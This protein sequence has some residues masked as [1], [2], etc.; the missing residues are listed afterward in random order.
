MQPA[1]H[2]AIGYLVWS[3]YARSR[4]HRPPTDRGAWIALFGALFPDLVDKPLAWSL[5][6]LPAGRSLAH[7]LLTASLFT[8]AAWW[9]GQ[10]VDEPALG[11]A[12]GLPYFSHLA[13][14]VV[15]PLASGQYAYLRFLGWPLL[16]LPPYDTSRSLLTE[17]RGSVG[18]LSGLE[19]LLA[20][21]VIAVWLL[22]GSP[23]LPIERAAD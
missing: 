2:L 9:V 17:F 5:H 23:G 7:S 4:L 21:V 8:A 12:F 11:L 16:S 1:A 14:D 18:T 22:D 15:R 3:A 19:L 13:A 10:R 6:V 20:A